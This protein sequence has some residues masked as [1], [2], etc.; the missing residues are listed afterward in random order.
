MKYFLEFSFFFILVFSL[1]SS[2]AQNTHINDVIPFNRNNH[3]HWVDSIMKTLSVDQKIAQL[4]MIAANSRESNEL[5][6]QKID[7]LIMHY[8]LGGVIF[9]QSGPN[10][11]KNLLD[12]YNRVSNLPLLTSIDAE[13]GLGM[14]LDSVELFPW[15]MTLGAIQDDNA[16][17]DFGFEVASQLKALGVHINFAPVLDVNNNPKNPIINFR[18][19]SDSPEI[20][21][22]YGI[23]FIK[24]IQDNGLYACAKHFPGHGN[25]SIDS[26]TS[27]PVI[28]SSL[29]ELDRIELKPFK[30]AVDNDVKMIKWKICLRP[31]NDL[32]A[33][34]IG[35]LEDWD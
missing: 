13:W 16:I 5:Y 2:Q 12:R 18:S 11:L 8:D 19:Y 20:V 30:N 15:M 27:L 14:R 3:T 24:G 32:K 1:S 9:F 31:L 34:E 17:Y 26:H 10:E 21:S 22:N 7:S 23:E 33:Q 28:H 25:T 4:F 6:Y 35:T 29:A